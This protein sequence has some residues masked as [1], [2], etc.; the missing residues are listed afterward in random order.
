[1]TNVTRT[2]GS[3]QYE[4]DSLRR[5]QHQAHER[6]DFAASQEVAEQISKLYMEFQQRL[7]QQA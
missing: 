6:K 5:V 7:N 2:L 3:I 1:M 4:I